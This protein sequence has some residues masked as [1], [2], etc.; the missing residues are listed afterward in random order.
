MTERLTP[1][2]STENAHAVAKVGK[3]KT[4]HSLAERMPS[5]ELAAKVG[6]PGI[7]A[8]R[9]TRRVVRHNARG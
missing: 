7:D 2:G 5:P 3:S 8:A 4:P 9:M 1:Y 6:Q